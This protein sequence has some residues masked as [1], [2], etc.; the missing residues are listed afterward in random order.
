M[1]IKYLLTYIVFISIVAENGYQLEGDSILFKYKPANSNDKVYV[2]GNFMDWEKN[3]PDWKMTYQPDGYFS[4]RKPIDKIKTPD[5][6][7]YEFTF[8]VNGKLIDANKNDEN[9]IHCAG[10][11]YRY[12]INWSEGVK[13]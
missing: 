11:G 5:R 10:Y 7:F 9:V 12:V 6:S 4:L 3:D 2:C 13:E 8:L 1:L